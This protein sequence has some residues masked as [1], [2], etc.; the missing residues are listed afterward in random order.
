M[1]KSSQVKL[2]IVHTFSFR[3]ARRANEWKVPV[4]RKF[5][6]PDAIHPTIYPFVRRSDA[7]NAFLEMHPHLH[8]A[9]SGAAATTTTTA[10]LLVV[11]FCA[12]DKNCCQTKLGVSHEFITICGEYELIMNEYKGESSYGSLSCSLAL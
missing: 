9:T 8:A 4:L 5:L 6:T 3:R 2:L 1:N 10:Q 7:L 11:M 12:C